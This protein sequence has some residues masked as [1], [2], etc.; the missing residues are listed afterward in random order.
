MVFNKKNIKN[1]TCT[2]SDSR[3]IKGIASRNV[4]GLIIKVINPIF[5]YV[6]FFLHRSERRVIL[7]ALSF[8]KVPG[9]TK[10]DFCRSP[11]LIPP[12]DQIYVAWLGRKWCSPSCITC[13]RFQ[14]LILAMSLAGCWR[15]VNTEDFQ[16]YR[17][18]TRDTKKSPVVTSSHNAWLRVRKICVYKIK[19]RCTYSTRDL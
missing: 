9:N 4:Q 19:M 2:S 17:S 16:V 14:I 1:K 3:Q 7:P 10:H 18:S 11:V 6:E 15:P 13:R 12:V 5:L 8:C